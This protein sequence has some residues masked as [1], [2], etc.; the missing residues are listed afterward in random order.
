[1]LPDAKSPT[2][3]ADE[4]D[5]GP[6]SIRSVE[7]VET[8]VEGR[9]LDDGAT[10]ELTSPEQ[11]ARNSKVAAKEG[12]IRFKAGSKKILAIRGGFPDSRFSAKLALMPYRPIISCLSTTL[13]GSNR[14]RRSQSR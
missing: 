8:L 12:M 10:G 11:A 2:D 3:P 9:G 6:V 5:P 14:K 13:C 1:M 4:V 7:V